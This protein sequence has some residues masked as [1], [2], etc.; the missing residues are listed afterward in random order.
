MNSQ[1][2]T[3][4]SIPSISVS[5]EGETVEVLQTMSQ[6]NG[7]R[8]RVFVLL[9]QHGTQ[10]VSPETL[11]SPGWLGSRQPVGRLERGLKIY[12]ADELGKIFE[13]VN[14]RK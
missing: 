1:I 6:G 4:L 11:A 5:P 7:K 9:G 14:V 3:S 2:S 13:A 12:D 10:F 8:T